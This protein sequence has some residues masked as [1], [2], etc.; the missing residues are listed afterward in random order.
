MMKSNSSVLI[1]WWVI[2]ILA[3]VV[4][5]AGLPTPAYCQTD[6]IALLIQQTPLNGGT[7]TPDIGVH[8][9]S[10]NTELT[11]TAIPKPGFQFV[12]W[13]GDVS[14]ST[15][16]RTIA[17]LDTPKIIIAVFERVEYEFLEWE[18]AATSTP[19]QGLFGSAADYSRGG[20]GGG[21]RRHG[22]GRPKPPE[23]EEDFPAPDEDGEGDFPVPVPE[24]ATAVLLILGGLLAFV[25]RK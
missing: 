22:G 8:H 9:F 6:G 5:A 24:P 2:V 10:M 11:L 4:I 20:G 3:I 12:Y 19:G 14:D 17:Y 18:E 7:I 25:R 15:T 13:L 1:G 16:S 21:I 23:P